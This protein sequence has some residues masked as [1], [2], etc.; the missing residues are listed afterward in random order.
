[1]SEA[2]EVRSFSDEFIERHAVMKFE[3]LSPKDMKDFLLAASTRGGLAVN[4]K[5]LG[6]TRKDNKEKPVKKTG[7]EVIKWDGLIGVVQDMYI[8]KMKNPLDKS[9]P[10]R[11]PG[12]RT[13][14]NLVKHVHSNWDMDAAFYDGKKQE[15]L[16]E[17]FLKYFVMIGETHERAQWVKA[18][19]ES[20][21]DARLWDEDEKKDAITE[22]LDGE[23]VIVE[24]LALL[25]DPGLGDEDKEIDKAL[26]YLQ[27]NTRSSN[28]K[29]TINT[30]EKKTN[31]LIKDWD[32]LDNKR[33]IERLHILRVIWQILELIRIHRCA[34]TGAHDSLNLEAMKGIET[35]IGSH[36]S[37]SDTETAKPE[38]WPAAVI[39]KEETL[40]EMEKRYEGIK[41][42]ELKELDKLI[43]K[44]ALAID[45]GDYVKTVADAIMKRLEAYDISNPVVYE[46]AENLKL[47]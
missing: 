43:F 22:Y 39:E 33:L 16:F 29:N 10:R 31:A 23:E 41:P 9:L 14:K 20:F 8:K 42:L 38:E 27:K 40:K 15:L 5:I 35:I 30:L 21:T 46:V 4:Q 18:L 2:F 1:G 19:K 45:C 47:S 26:V 17:L 28:V 37:I 6:D 3:Y 13:L 25:R 24:E 44:L 11:V 34:G 12:L 32:T 36:L 7:T